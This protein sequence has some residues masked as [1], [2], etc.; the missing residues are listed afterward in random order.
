MHQGRDAAEESR[1]HSTGEKAAEFRIRGALCR[2]VREEDAGPA[3]AADST[4]NAVEQCAEQVIGDCRIDGRRY[5]ILCSNS[6]QEPSPDGGGIA[7]AVYDVSVEGGR[8][9]LDDLAHQIIVKM[10]RP[11]LV[12]R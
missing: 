9:L 10:D 3:C 12:V 5:L 11:I 2:V 7:F 6:E 8:I 1:G 4:A